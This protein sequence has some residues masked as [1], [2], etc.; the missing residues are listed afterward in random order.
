M[1][2]QANR[3]LKAELLHAIFMLKNLNF[4][5]M[6]HMHGGFGGFGR[7]HGPGG[8]GGYGPGA[9]GGH[10]VN[11]AE[12]AFLKQQAER[13]EKDETGGAWLSQ[14]RDYLCV[15]KAAVSQML[16]SLESKGLITRAADPENR[17]TII[18]KLTAV[19]RETIDK[20][21]R[22]FDENIEML[23]GR[24]GEEDTREII[25]LIYKFAGIIEDI[26]IEAAE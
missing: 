14:M 6:G 1:T 15:S 12:F 13:E 25:R 3:E 8:P 20:I 5:R 2:T 11:M 16:G 9:C 18:V 4:Q 24:F 17:R 19:G 26:K 10:I 22:G 23:M 7:R 21:E